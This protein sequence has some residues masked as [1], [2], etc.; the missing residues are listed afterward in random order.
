MIKSGITLS[1]TIEIKQWLVTDT[2]PT[3]IENS[4]L[5]KKVQ[6]NKKKRKKKIP[7]IC[8]NR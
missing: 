5:R 8:K 7:S 1:L 3:I 2:F 4:N 6:I